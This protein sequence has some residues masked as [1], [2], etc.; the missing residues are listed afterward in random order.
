[1]IDKKSREV[2]M[3]NGPILPRVLEFSLPLML[4]GMLQLLYNAADIVVVG[5]FAGPQALAAVGSTGALVNLLVGLFMGFSVGANVV[6][7]RDLGAGRDEDVRRSVHTSITLAAVS[8][9]LLAFSV[10]VTRSLLTPI[11][12][13]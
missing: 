7:A 8:G 12:L 3:L 9:L 1:M 6:V 11:L 13:H 2:D 5:R 10:R 4:S